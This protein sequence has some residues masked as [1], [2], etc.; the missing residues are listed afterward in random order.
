M[1]RL[2]VLWNNYDRGGITGNFKTISHISVDASKVPCIAGMSPLGFPVFIQQ[3]EVIYIYGQT[4]FKAQVS[5]K[6]EVC[7]SRT[8]LGLLANIPTTP[9]P[10]DTEKRYVF[11]R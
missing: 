6:E 4:E 5:W 1:N 9:P 2:V 7:L 11:Q 8:I 3:F 10:Q